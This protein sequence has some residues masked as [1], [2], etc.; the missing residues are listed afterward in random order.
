MGNSKRQRA[1]ESRNDPSVDAFLDEYIAICRRHMLCLSH[2]DSGG[3]F[4]VTKID[5]DLLDWVYGAYVE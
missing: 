4:I 3:S 1:S 5:G 2:E